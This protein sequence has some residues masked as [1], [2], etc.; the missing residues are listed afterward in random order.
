[1]RQEVASAVFYCCLKESQAVSF[2]NDYIRFAVC[3]D[4]TSEMIKSKRTGSFLYSFRTDSGVNEIMQVNFDGDRRVG[5]LLEDAVMLDIYK[6]FPRLYVVDSSE[7]IIYVID[8]TID[9][10]VQLVM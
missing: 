2:E 1:M 7:E 10:V 8:L 4:E 6:D 5:T 3:Q 9:Q